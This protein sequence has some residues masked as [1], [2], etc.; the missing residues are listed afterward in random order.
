MLRAL[1]EAHG[2]R[3]AAAAELWRRRTELGRLPAALARRLR[4]EHGDRGKIGTERELTCGSHGD[5]QKA[6]QNF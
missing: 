3:E 1:E 2:A 4:R 6:P 5:L